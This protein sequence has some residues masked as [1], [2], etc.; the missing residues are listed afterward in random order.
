MKTKL[1]MMLAFCPAIAFSSYQSREKEILKRVLD[2]LEKVETAS[3]YELSKGWQPGDTI[4]TDYLHFCEEY[5]N[6]MDSTLGVSF[7]Y[8]DAKDT[9]Q[10]DACYDGTL[11][12][13]M[14][15]EHKGVVIDDFT[16]NSYSF[17]TK[18]PPFFNYTKNIIR[19]VLNT[20]DSISVE[21]QETT[22]DYHLKLTINEDQ[23]IEFFGKDCR[24]PK[25]PYIFGDPTSVYEL[26]ISKSSGLPYRARREMSHNTSERSYRAVELNKS[27]VKSILVGDYIPDGYI[28]RKKGDKTKGD[29]ETVTLLGKKAP[30]WKLNDTNGQPV[31]LSDLESK[32]IVMNFTG[33]GCGPCR[34]AIPFLNSIKELFPTSDCEV[35]SVE[36]WENKMHSL[37]VYSHKNQMNYK[38]LEGNDAIVKDYLNGNRGVPVFL[39]L[40][41]TRTVRKII[42]GYNPEKTGQEIVEVIKGVLS[43]T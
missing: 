12:A 32:V 20:N 31:S 40:D 3:Y 4:S 26:W 14:W 9:T 13:S 25:N 11:Y 28:V 2:N 17:R 21:W 33:I 1:M 7:V 18:T 36:C 23:Q 16:T 8:R 22:D 6:P 41:A 30:D 29:S 24:M 35:I 19:Y 37:S 39:I 15:H 42:T 34:V 43:S 5:D 27:Q 38:F 10:V